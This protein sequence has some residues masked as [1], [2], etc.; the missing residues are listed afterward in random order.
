[1]TESDLRKII[2]ASIAASLLGACST[3]PDVQVAG[4][5]HLKVTEHEASQLQTTATCTR[6][7]GMPVALMLLA[8]PIACANIDLDRWACDLYYSNAT[9]W[10]SLHHEREHCAGKWHDDGLQNYRDAWRSNLERDL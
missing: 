6:L 8:L 3:M 5:E 2:C 4:L 10:L 9:G 1:M 7:M